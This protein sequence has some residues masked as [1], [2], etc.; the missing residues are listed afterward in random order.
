MRCTGFS[1][2]L[3]A[4]LSIAAIAGCAAPRLGSSLPS[5][6]SSGNARSFSARGNSGCNARKAPLPGT[7]VVFES[8]GNVT[9]KA[10]S[11]I[12]AFWVEGVARTMPSPSPQPSSDPVTPTQRTYLYSGTYRLEKSAQTGCAYLETTV[13]GKPLADS[14]NNASLSG[15]PNFGTKL[16]AFDGGKSGSLRIGDLRLTANGGHATL[17]LLS[18][19]RVYD[20]AS[21]TLT[22]RRIRRGP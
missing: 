15:M 4:S 17:T 16:I 7:Y 21:L 22:S 2:N 9:G 1:R 14:R 11:A 12:D 5:S 19:H 6:G 18:G 20:T 13:D 10:Y 3:L 8:D